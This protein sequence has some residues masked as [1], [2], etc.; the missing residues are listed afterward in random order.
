VKYFSINLTTI[1][2]LAI[3]ADHSPGRA[4]ATKFISGTALVGGLAATHRFLYPE[5]SHDFEYFF[6]RDWIS[7]PNLYPAAFSDPG[8]QDLN[9]PIYPV[10]KTAQSCKRHPGFQFPG[11][12]E[13]DFHGVRDSLIDWALFKMATAKAYDPGNTQPLKV[14]Q[15]H[16]RCRHCDALMDAFSGYYRRD[17]VEPHYMIDAQVDS[18][19]RLQTHTGINRES[20][21]VQEGILYNR[22]VFEEGMH[23]WGALKLPDDEDLAE[24]FASFIGEVNDEHLVRL[25]TGRTRGLGKV[26]FAIEG[27]EDEDERHTQ[28]AERLQ[29]FDELL[30]TKAREIHLHD[31]KQSYFVLTLHSPLI[32]HDNLLRYRGTIDEDTLAELLSVPASEF[33]CIYQAASIRRVTGWH[34]LW[35][36]PR[37]NEYAIE[38]GSVFLFGSSQPLAALLGPLFELEEQ[39]AGKRRTEGFGRVCVS[40]AFHKE[41]KQR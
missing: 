1:S 19:T 13:D 40:D 31:L 30:K 3:R 29:A 16:K 22:Q 14:L 24:R 7:Y 9:L 12:D 18:H 35:G 23:F 26:S 36:T 8:M 20:G 10:P 4:E 34:E 39:G 2:P 32:L 33:E 38:T 11:E 27:M 25:G 17:E 41:I 6:L 15:E 28:F 21:T 37:T 5:K